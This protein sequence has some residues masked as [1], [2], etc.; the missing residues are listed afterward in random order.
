MRKDIAK[1]LDDILLKLVESKDRSYDFEFE[2]SE[3][4]FQFDD[5]LA[6]LDKNKH[7]AGWGADDISRTVFI[8]PKGSAFIMNGGY[9]GVIEEKERKE[10]QR[11]EELSVQQQILHKMQAPQAPSVHIHTTDGSKKR[12]WGWFAGLTLVI[13]GITDWYEG[14]NII[15][16]VIGYILSR[17]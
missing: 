9:T 6:I 4:A 10:L 16:K 8:S 14:F 17:L 1:K 3:E 13:G 2:T 15:K 5:Y 11:K 7:I 12:T